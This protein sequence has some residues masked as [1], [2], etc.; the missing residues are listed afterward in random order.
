MKWICQH[1]DCNAQ[2][3]CDYDVLKHWENDIKKM[4]KK[5]STKEQFSKYLEFEMM[6]RYWSKCEYELIV[7]R[8]GDR[9]ILS[10]WAGCRE[11]EKVSIDVTD[12][13][14]FDWV[15]FA[16]KHISLSQRCSVAKIDIYDQLKYRWEEFVDYCWNYPHKYQRRKANE[17]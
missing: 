9:V 5:S 7:E 16:E 4:K 13:T 11:P 10:P 3:I 17:I 6:Y 8:A 15:G 2:R 14:D 1:F 12:R